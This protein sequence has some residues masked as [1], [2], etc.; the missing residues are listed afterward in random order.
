MLY[1]QHSATHMLAAL[2]DQTEL[3][4]LL[5]LEDQEH[6]AA[7]LGQQALRLQPL[8][9]LQQ[10]HTLSLRQTIMAVLVLQVQL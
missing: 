1:L 8:H 2:A 6:S 7:M 9:H 5:V 3:Q 10:E 4:P